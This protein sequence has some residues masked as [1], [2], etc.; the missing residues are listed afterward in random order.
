MVTIDCETDPFLHGRIPQPFL[1]D[2]YDG[3]R[4]FTFEHTS[5]C[6][7]FLAQNRFLAYAHNG[8]KFDYH[9][10]GVLSQLEE[11][12]RLLIINGRVARFKIGDCEFRDSFNILPIPLRNYKKK[13]I[14]YSKLE[15]KC[16]HQHMQEIKE[17]LQSDTQYLFELVTAFRNQYG[18]NV[19]LAGA[20]MRQWQ[21]MGGDVPRSTAGFYED[22]SP[23]YYGGRVQCFHKGE[24]VETFNL[25]DINSAYPYAMMHDHPVATSFDVSEPDARD[26]IIPQSLYCIEATALNTLPLRDGNKLRFNAQG[27]QVYCVTGWEV[28][29]G[30][31]TNRLKVHSVR[32]R[33][34]FA[35]TINF[36]KYVRRF[37][38]MK[39]SAP[40][41]SPEYIFAKL[42][43]NSLY[44][45]YGANPSNY[46]NH[47][48]CQPKFV[49]AAQSDGFNFAG[50]LGPWALL[51]SEL[52]E[53]QVRYYN[54]ATA[55]SVTGFVRAYLLR[56]LD[57]IERT[58]GRALYCDTDSIAFVGKIPPFMK[59]TKELGDWSHEGTFTRGGIAGRKLYAFQGQDG[60]WKTASK[61]VKLGPEAIMRVARG[62]AEV[63][64]RDAPSFSAT[65]APSFVTRTVRRIDDE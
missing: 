34:D 45:K 32:M 52:E 64:K 33:L 35:K 28:L 56:H 12:Q 9:M 18:D 11:W 57:A 1:W 38:E 4:H 5:D 47:T 20:A 26:D 49:E 51:E 62:S 40:K 55:A 44:G 24:I 50:E 65:S 39:K 31:E 36:Q 37:Y 22:I 23:Y 2:V 60:K 46:K 10:P 15:K 3:E 30:L 17:Y 16:R 27:R 41:D 63:Y 14:D 13:E 25:C 42:F 54:A 6:F 43:M 21:S 53:A 61:G 59:I 7:H 48:I 58:G 29:A 19:T 8:G